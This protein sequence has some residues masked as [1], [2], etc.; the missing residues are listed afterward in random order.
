MDSIGFIDSF[1]YVK[2]F[3]I[4]SCSIGFNSTDLEYEWEMGYRKWDMGMSRRLL[5]KPIKFQYDW[6]WNLEFSMSKI[7]GNISVCLFVFLCKF[8]SPLVRANIDE[9]HHSMRNC[10]TMLVSI[11]SKVFHSMKLIDLFD[12]NISIKCQLADDGIDVI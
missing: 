8:V 2:C 5:L 4:Y 10:L 7:L 1:H 6:V 12:S 9:I 3:C 11:C